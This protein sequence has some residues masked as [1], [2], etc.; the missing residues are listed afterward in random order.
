[1]PDTPQSELN[2]AGAMSATLL[3]M[4]DTV[5]DRVLGKQTIDKSGKPLRQVAYMHLPNGIPIDPRD[6]RDPWKPSAGATLS[7][8]RESGKL[9][10]L[11]PASAPSDGGATPAA[12]SPPAPAQDA[13]L[14]AAMESALNIASLF[15]EMPMVTGDGTYR[16]YPTTRKLSSAYEG[17]LQVV[18]AVP[19]KPQP[20]EIVK[21]VK[22]A[23][24]VLYNLD[25]EGNI[26]DYTARFNNWLTFSQAYADAKSEFARA[27]A[28]AMTD[29][30][31]GATWPVTAASQQQK[32]DNAYRIWRSSGADEVEKALNTLNSQGGS[33]AAYFVSQARELFDKWDLSLS[34]VVAVKTP[35]TQILPTSWYDHTNQRIGFSDITVESKDVHSKAGGK[36]SSFANNWYKGSSKSTQAG[37]KASFF[38]ISVGGQGGSSSSQSSV[39]AHQGG[40]S[41]NYHEDQ[42]TWAKISFQFGVVNILRPWLLTELFHIDGW[43]V[44]EHPIGCVSDGT[45][46]GQ[47]GDDHKILPMIT[48][49]ALVI[50]NVK[51]E[52]SGWGSAGTAL[53][54]HRANQAAESSSSSWNAG[55]SVGFMGFGASASHSQSKFGG[56][57]SNDKDASW[58]FNYDE[59]HDKG[60]LTIKGSQIAGFVGEI[61]GLNPLIDGGKPAAGALPS[62]GATK[63]NGAGAA[64]PAAPAGGTR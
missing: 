31:F 50:R 52:A 4:L 24:K 16:P 14:M 17:L 18:Q 37:G 11:P 63:S 57:S 15:N 47:E 28:Q 8:M 60:T 21:A 36:S 12:G 58:D 41:S 59:K 5:V 23:Q 10:E 61:V 51:I 45:V 48:T 39:E 33:A 54:Q 62:G 29:P 30:V 55:G 64:T 7:S 43:Y 2:D 56:S 22:A 20:P 26:S 27:E 49:Q 40:D 42:T 35:Y 13:K 25:D 53:A 32:V 44:P 19:P 34:G 46:A 3:N 9:P 38:G 6:F 1:M